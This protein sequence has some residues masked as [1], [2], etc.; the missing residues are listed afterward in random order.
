MILRTLFAFLLVAIAASFATAQNADEARPAAVFPPLTTGQ[1]AAKQALI[2]SIDV[3]PAVQRPNIV[4]VFADDLGYAD[5]GCFGSTEIPT[6]HIDALVSS[7]MKFTNAYVTAGTCSPSRAGLLTGQYQH[8]FGFEFNTDITVVERLGRG[9]D[10]AAV[11]IADVLGKAGYQTGAVGKWHLG[12]REQFHPLNRG[13]GSFYGFLRG[14]HRYLPRGQQLLLRGFDPVSEDEYLTDA[15]A[16]EAVDFVNGQSDD[17]PFFLYVPFNAVHTPLQATEKYKNRFS[18]VEDPRRRTYYAMT[19]AMD[20]AVGRIVEAIDAKGF[21]ENTMMIFFNDNGGPLYTGVQSNGP[22]RMGKLF[23]FEGGVRVPLVIKW[24]AAV[25]GGSVCDGIVSS[26]DMLPTFSSV[27]GVTLPSSLNTDG[28]NLQPWLTDQRTDSPSETLFWRN[29]Q[30]KA[31]R[32]GKWKMV[33]VPNHVWLF[34][35]EE[36][37]G[38]RNNLAEQHP[39]VVRQLQREF[40]DWEATIKEPAWPPKARHP[41]ETIDGVEYRVDV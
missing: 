15:F 7:G 26:L 25:E 33:E 2:D 13:F 29:G 27:A 14:G 22:L 8:R 6:P 30:N 32:K 18:K 28:V 31:I 12:T 38:E 5:I 37:I 36:D 35:L 1:Q 20:D 9:L 17:T 23:L 24:P 4:L 11:T 41:Q 21:S 39:D 16:R 34:D 19:S 40:R 10:P 3:S